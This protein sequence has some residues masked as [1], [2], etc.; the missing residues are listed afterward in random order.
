M[1]NNGKQLEK[2]LLEMSKLKE[3]RDKQLLNAEIII[4]ILAIIVILGSIFISIVIPKDIYRILIIVFGFIVF[5]IAM[6][7]ALRIEQTAG[8]YE[9][10][11]CHYKYVP[12]YLYMF[13]A[14][15]IGRTRYMKCPKCNKYSWNKKVLSNNCEK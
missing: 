2:D 14:M 11:K 9:C 10:K 4:V 6:L 3:D 15:H 12:T 13:F 5:F 1:K 8:Y 7:F